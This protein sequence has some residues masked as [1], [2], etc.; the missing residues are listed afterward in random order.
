MTAG[1]APLNPENGVLEWSVMSFDG[2]PVSTGAEDLLAASVPH[3]GGV[4]TQVDFVLEHSLGWQR[5]GIDFQQADDGQQA[6]A[7]ILVF[8]IRGNS[9]PCGEP[10]AA[11]CAT[12]AT[13]DGRPVCLV[14]AANAWRSS[15]LI[16]HEIGHCLGLDHSDGPGVMTATY[17][18]SRSWPTDDEIESVRP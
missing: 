9:V 8:V 13:L 4:E 12:P 2:D 18:N 15:I 10:G 17:S 16:N 7:D 5:S 11:G 14:L 3:N 1:S 6:S